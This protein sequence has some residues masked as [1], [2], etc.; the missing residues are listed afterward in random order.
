MTS[1]ALDETNPPTTDGSKV[2]NTVKKIKIHLHENKKVYIGTAVGIAVGA[3]GALILKKSYDVKVAQQATQAALVNWK[4]TILQEQHITVELPARGHRGDV[5]FD[6]TNK[7]LYA[8]RNAAAE[9]LGV[10]ATTIAQHLK[11]LR[12]HVKGSVLVDL[13]ENLTEEV[14][15]SV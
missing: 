7:K 4:P 9:A 12:D 1:K 15:I 2:K 13:G 3:A 8:S 10:S 11:G 5:I 6:T 14:K